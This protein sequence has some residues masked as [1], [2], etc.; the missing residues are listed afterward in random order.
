MS[1]Y[2]LLLKSIEQLTETATD[3]FPYMN[4]GGCCVFASV[5]ADRLQSIGLK[6]TIVSSLPWGVRRHSGSLPS[7]DDVRQELIQQGQSTLIRLNWDRKGMSFCH[8]GVQ[9]MIGGKL[10]TIDS[11][12]IRD[13][14]MLG[15]D[16]YVLHPGSYTVREGASFCQTGEWNSTFRAVHNKTDVCKM[17]RDIVPHSLRSALLSE[18]Q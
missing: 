3:E 1:V 14:G 2:G 13:D 9:C 11:N 4:H 6:P 15:A 12:R 10:L 7:I 16:S 18:Q 8:V 17:I 5:L